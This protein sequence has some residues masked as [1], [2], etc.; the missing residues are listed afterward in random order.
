MKPTQIFVPML[1]IVCTKLSNND[2]SFVCSCSMY[3]EKL[4]LS[5]ESWKLN[6]LTNSVNKV[7]IFFLVDRKLNLKRCNLLT[8]SQQLSFDFR[9]TVCIFKNIL[10]SP[11]WL[12]ISDWQWHLYYSFFGKF[13]I[14]WL[15]QVNRLGKSPHKEDINN[16]ENKREINDYK[17]LWSRKI[18]TRWKIWVSII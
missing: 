12:S 4:P 15:A 9:G 8:V 11:F 16:L 17:E 5:L 1:F 7:R 6:S 10:C 13:S 14:S 2:W 3:T 18:S